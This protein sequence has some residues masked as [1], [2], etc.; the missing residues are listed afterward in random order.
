VGQEEKL[1]SKLLKKKT[2]VKKKGWTK[3]N[4]QGTDTTEDFKK[5]DLG[6]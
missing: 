3:I 4:Q 6:D 5:E 1:R 2:Y